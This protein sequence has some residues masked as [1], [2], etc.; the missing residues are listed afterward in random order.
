M[1]R[2][3]AIETR[4]EKLTP[5]LDEFFSSGF[6]TRQEVVEVSR[7]RT[8]WEYRLV[9]KPLLL[10]DV[11][12]AIQYELQLEDKLREYCAASKLSLRHRWV[13]LERIEG[14]YRIGLKNLRVPAERE[15]LRRECVLFLRKFGRKGAL[16]K[17]YA[18]WM[19]QSPTR[20][21]IWIE[22]AEWSAIDDK[23]V[24]NGRAIIQQAL[25][26]MASVPEVWASAVKIELHMCHRLLRGL[27]DSHR[28][29]IKREREASGDK[30][31][32][33]F[34]FSELGE[35][36]R[37]ENASMGSILLDLELARTVVDEALSGPAS[38]PALVQLLGRTAAAFPLSAELIRELRLEG[39][40][41][42]LRTARSSAGD[43]PQAERTKWEEGL[44]ALLWDCAAVEH[45]LVSS[46]PVAVTDPAGFIATGGAPEKP[47]T[48]VR[49]HAA[50]HT[51]ITSCTLVSSAQ[52]VEAWPTVSAIKDI[53][54]VFTDG[55]AGVLNSLK[56]AGVPA[57]DLS[58]IAIRFLTPAPERAITATY[59]AKLLLPGPTPKM[60]KAG[61]VPAPGAG[62]VALGKSLAEELL[63]LPPAGRKVRRDP[64]SSIFWLA[65]SLSPFV[66]AED[67]RDVVTPTSFF[68]AAA[69]DDETLRRLLL[70][71]DSLDRLEA[72]QSPEEVAA[73]RAERGRAALR[74]LQEHQVLP[75]TATLSSVEDLLSR[76][77]LVPY[78]AGK[79]PVALWRVFEALEKM[80]AD[81]TTSAATPPP[82]CSSSSSSDDSEDVPQRPS[83]PSETVSSFAMAGLEFLVSVG[84][85]TLDTAEEWGAVVGICAL[86]RSRLRTLGCPASFSRAEMEAAVRDRGMTWV[87]RVR[88]FIGET[89]RCR[90]RPRWVLVALVIPFLEAVAV[91]GPGA[92]SSAMVEARAAHEEVLSLYGL[93]HYPDQYA[94]LLYDADRDGTA[95]AP[96]AQRGLA[97]A[98]SA[99]DWGN[100][101]AFERFVARDLAKANKV[102][103]RA[104]RLCLAPQALLI[105]NHHLSAEAVAHGHTGN[106]Y[107]ALMDIFVVGHFVPQRLQRGV[108]VS[109]LA[110]TWCASELKCPP[111]LLP[112]LL[113]ILSHLHAHRLLSFIQAKSSSSVLA[114]QQPLPRR[115]AAAETLRS[116][117]PARPVVL[118]WR[119]AVARGDAARLL[120]SLVPLGA[121]TAAPAPLSSASTSLLL[122]EA[123]VEPEVLHAVA[124]CLVASA[125]P[126][127][128]C[129]PWVAARLGPRPAPAAGVDDFHWEPPLPPASSSSL[130]E[131]REHNRRLSLAVL[132][133]VAKVLPA[134]RTPP[135]S[136]LLI[137]LC[138]LCLAPSDEEAV[139]LARRAK[140]RFPEA[141]ACALAAYCSLSGVPSESEKSV[142]SRWLA[143]WERVGDDSASRSSGPRCPAPP[144]HPSVEGVLQASSVR[145]F[146]VAWE[147]HCV[148]AAGGLAAADA[149]PRLL[150][151]GRDTPA[152]VAACLP[153]WA[154]VEWLTQLPASVRRGSPAVANAHGA[155]CEKILSSAATA[156]RKGDVGR[157]ST[158]HGQRTPFAVRVHPAS[159]S[160]AAQS[161][162]LEHLLTM[163]TH[164]SCDSAL[165]SY[166]FILDRLRGLWAVQNAYAVAAS[167][168]PPHD[169][170]TLHRVMSS[171]PSEWRTRALSELIGAIRAALQWAITGKVPP[172]AGLGLA[173]SSLLHASVPAAWRRER[174]LAVTDVVHE[175]TSALVALLTLCANRQEALPRRVGVPSWRS[176]LHASATVRSH[177]YEVLLAELPQ[178]ELSALLQLLLRYGYVEAGVEL[179][180]CLVSSALLD[181]RFF[182]ASLLG[183]LYLGME[184][185]AATAQDL[186]RQRRAQRDLK[187]LYHQRITVFGEDRVQEL[188]A[189][190]SCESAT[191]T[192]VAQAL[193]LRPWPEALSRISVAGLHTGWNLFR[194]DAKPNL[195]DWTTGVA[196]R[197]TPPSPSGMEWIIKLTA[198]EK[199]NST[200]KVADV[201]CHCAN[202]RSTVSNTRF[203]SVIPSLFS[204]LLFPFTLF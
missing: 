5:S 102:M 180:R 175:G 66:R 151:G 76:R 93:S 87:A 184:A 155:I 18:E 15:E 146:A 58:D 197:T 181:L 131:A 100:Y 133:G 65:A 92:G 90:P 170:K 44:A 150:C 132:T 149:F 28:A 3:R 91:A 49:V 24:D 193:T 64:G 19:I 111:T 160:A 157:P 11:R 10:L 51:L 97:K 89:Q 104:R 72:S 123:L 168:V 190:G 127:P 172:S 162:L 79:T 98:L 105:A 204:S 34:R 1:S 96:A 21:D 36:L 143:L 46:G 192:A 63:V 45:F 199:F 55:I 48:A 179:G 68:G 121:G 106:F 56:R 194:S 187:L 117:A 86:I 159:S 61:S 78:A 84:R 174:S 47:T 176:K 144:L 82:S 152:A 135:G 164:M 62:A 129:P 188:A 177:K 22:A 50:A 163:A 126:R 81:Q 120:A 59:L 200:E 35:R 169:T 77:N 158:T 14:L 147:A 52:K 191:R 203:L 16:S 182:S 113:F 183:S 42:G 2:S 137:A 27:L 80:R 110:D 37:A 33:D 23:N 128:M 198:K 173:H 73:S 186:P 195:P 201:R 166:D 8:H 134:H 32:V 39:L 124:A 114:I 165:H 83:R 116:A 140:H 95:A 40:R 53:R 88:R 25:L 138:G 85:G 142:E 119:D 109:V 156:R 171:T 41:R 17:L 189:M 20:S 13:M 161:R 118:C 57:A 99:E 112:L 67:V 38:G 115:R 103:E 154:K 125:V 139:E 145:A 178:S 74:L 30:G 60:K 130:A 94:A 122:R 167:L 9:A 70:W 75:A 69:L 12:Q 148:L 6:L 141:A 185:T 196:Q 108:S 54:H 71:W 7:Q 107:E 202:F 136:A 4:L 26:T 153:M 29:E 43:V 31:P 101:V